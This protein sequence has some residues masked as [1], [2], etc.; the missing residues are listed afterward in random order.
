MTIQSWRLC[1]SRWVCA[2]E[3]SDLQAN[4]TQQISAT[5]FKTLESMLEWTVHV[6]REQFFNREGDKSSWIRLRIEKPLAVPFADAPAVE[7][8]R[9]VALK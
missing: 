6:L 7:I 3:I 2:D 4:T 5:E 1:F 9:P 8:T